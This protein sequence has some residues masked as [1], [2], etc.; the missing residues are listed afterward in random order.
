MESIIEH[1]FT[2]SL[3]T[4]YRKKHEMH[5]CTGNRVELIH[6]HPSRLVPKGKLIMLVWQILHVTIAHEQGEME[7]DKTNKFTAPIIRC[8]TSPSKVPKRI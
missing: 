5:K 4:F 2:Y 8:T 1:S 7:L 6:T 3:K